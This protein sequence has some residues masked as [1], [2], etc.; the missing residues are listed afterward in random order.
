MMVYE[1]ISF[2][3]IPLSIFSDLKID[4]SPRPSGYI[5]GIPGAGG[6]GIKKFYE[7][8]PVSNIMNKDKWRAA[9]SIFKL[10]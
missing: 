8:H 6:V 5:L 10:P 7:V 9:I 4:F 1:Q 2:F 3:I